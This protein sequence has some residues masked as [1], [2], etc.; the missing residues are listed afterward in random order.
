MEYYF[1]PQFT[2][3][4]AIA[5]IEHLELEIRSVRQLA[6][7]DVDRETAE[8]LIRYDLINISQLQERQKEHLEA[9]VR[10]A[11]E[12]AAVITTEADVVI[13]TEADVDAEAEADTTAAS[14]E[15]D[16]D[17]VVIEEVV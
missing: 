11:A 13:T 15:G 1:R 17:G 8:A 4:E 16:D 7:G 14:A 12:A 6:I 2:I 5:L 9:K 3:P 10:A